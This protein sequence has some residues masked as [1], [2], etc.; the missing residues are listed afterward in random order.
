MNEGASGGRSSPI[1]WLTKRRYL[2]QS[3]RQ[4]TLRYT[5]LGALELSLSVG[6]VYIAFFV[7]AVAN[8]PPEFFSKHLSSLIE[9]EMAGNRELLVKDFIVLRTET[10]KYYVNIYDRSIVELIVLAVVMSPF[11]AAPGLL[12]FSAATLV[13]LRAIAMI[14]KGLVAGTALFV[15]LTPSAMLTGKVYAWLSATEEK[16]DIVINSLSCWLSDTD[17]FRAV[18]TLTNTTN[19]PLMLIGEGFKIELEYFSLTA[20]GRIADKPQDSKFFAEDYA[21][22]TG[23]EI[24]TTFTN[25]EEYYLLLPDESGAVD[26]YLDDPRK[27]LR[28]RKLA[29]REGAV[30]CSII[31][32][33]QGIT[34]LRIQQL[35]DKDGPGTWLSYWVMVPSPDG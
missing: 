15:F 8:F 12:F 35:S 2:L 31:A 10:G 19:R 28:A 3:K 33:A 30:K 29:E 16:T 21:D 5:R 9:W 18:L 20:T 34:R 7:I 11:L 32:R 14:S 27:L 24:Q 23:F 1:K 17:P 6:I 4:N 13:R 25:L 26:L 22:V